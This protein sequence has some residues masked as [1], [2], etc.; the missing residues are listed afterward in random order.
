MTFVDKQVKRSVTIDDI[1]DICGYAGEMVCDVL[2]YLNNIV[3][4]I[5]FTHEISRDSLY[6]LD[7]TVLKKFPS[8]LQYRCGR[9]KGRISLLLPKLQTETR[10]NSQENPRNDR[11]VLQN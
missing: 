3:P 4:A 1:D 11:V 9:G 2:D 7:T 5:K 8:A 10:N 6:F